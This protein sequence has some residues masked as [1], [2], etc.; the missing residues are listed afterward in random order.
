MRMRLLRRYGIEV[1]TDR[2]YP[3]CYFHTNNIWIGRDALLNHGVHIENVARVEIGP[4]TAL[5]IFTVVLTS[6]HEIGSKEQRCG[7]WLRQPVSIGSGSWI[8]A[9][10]TI[11]PGV[12]IGDGCV[13]A[14][15]SLVREDC[16][17]DGLYAGVPA[18]RI[19]DL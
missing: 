15:G 7:R 12:T 11:L 5:G 4:L 16:G 10:S 9:R 19:K 3:H 18:R 6:N 2:I 1:E 14:A 13:V 17:A 8:G